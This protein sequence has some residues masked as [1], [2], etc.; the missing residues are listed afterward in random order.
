[1]STYIQTNER[2]RVLTAACAPAH[3]PIVG[4][5]G[6]QGVPAN[7]P[8]LAEIQDQLVQQK[9]V[10]LQGAQLQIQGIN[11]STAKATGMA[12]SPVFTGARASGVPPRGRPV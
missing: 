11:G 6:V 1:M 4:Y 3:E 5:L 8:R 9:S 10:Q 7:G 12:K 2:P